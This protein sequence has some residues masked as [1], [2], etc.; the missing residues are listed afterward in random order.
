MVRHFSRAYQN[1]PVNYIYQQEKIN[2]V[3]S[4]APGAIVRAAISPAV[5]IVNYVTQNKK[6]NNKI[7]NK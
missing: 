5:A 3:I 7:N 2:Q 1:D 6:G 4:N